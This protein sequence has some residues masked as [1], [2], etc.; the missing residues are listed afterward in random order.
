MEIEKVR[1]NSGEIFAEE[2]SNRFHFSGTYINV[3]N[4]P[5]KNTSSLQTYGW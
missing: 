1:I 3:S 2:E 5:Q 4:C